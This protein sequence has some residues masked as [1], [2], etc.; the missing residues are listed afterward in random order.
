MDQLLTLF[1]YPVDLQELLLLEKPG[2]LQRLLEVKPATDNLRIYYTY[3][4][5]LRGRLLEIE[6]DLAFGNFIHKGYDEVFADA[7][8]TTNN[9]NQVNA[10]G[11]GTPGAIDEPSGFQ[12]FETTGALLDQL[13][14]NGN[15]F[16][17]AQLL[18]SGGGA[19]TA[20]LI[21][22]GLEAD[23]LLSDVS[24]SGD[25][26]ASRLFDGEVLENPFYLDAASVWTL[27][28]SDLGLGDASY[29]AYAGREVHLQSGNYDY[30]PYLS[31][32][33]DTVI[34]SSAG[35]MQISGEVAFDAGS[36]SVQPCIVLMSGGS[37]TSDSGTTLSHALSDLILTAR[38]DIDLTGTTISVGNYLDIL[39]Q[40][41]V[42]IT[43]GSL[44]ASGSIHLQAAKKLHLDSVQFSQNLPSLYL[45]ATTVNLRNL[46]FP[47][48]SYINASS[49]KGA[50]D[51]KYPNFGSE[52]YGR[53]NFIQNVKYGGNLMDDRTSF[54]LHGQNITI[55]KIP[56]Q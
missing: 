5:A 43:D 36:S 34:V 29:L 10:Q 14:A 42:T 12:L 48:G 46:D 25:F 55:G 9:L 30:G 8:L 2:V 45:Q 21:E 52:S 18:E 54:D 20:E 32:P 13:I 40:G 38:D 31:G 35:N 44:Q 24:M 4:V 11:E 16:I 27:T 7:L 6:N 1:G 49:L 17:L 50:I 51:G 19:L 41:D 23:F 26:D 15:E 22:A 47:S 56:G 37:I 3:A 53:V 33:V 28:K 39:G